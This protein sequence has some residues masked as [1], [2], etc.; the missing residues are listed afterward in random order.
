[1]LHSLSQLLPFITH[2]HVANGFRKQSRETRAPVILS[3]S[4]VRRGDKDRLGGLRRGRRAGGLLGWTLNS[5]KQ[6]DWTQ[7]SN[8]DG[9]AG[10]NKQ[11]L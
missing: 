3:V 4:A 5:C 9:E 11:R 6:G 10:E 2:C 8:G 1:M 7:P